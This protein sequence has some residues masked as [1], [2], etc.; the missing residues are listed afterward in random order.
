[1]LTPLSFQAFNRRVTFD[2]DIV[3]TLLQ[4]FIPK[5]RNIKWVLCTG[6]GHE[7]LPQIPRIL[8]QSFVARMSRILRQYY[9]THA[10]LSMRACQNSSAAE[11]M[12]PLLGAQVQILIPQ[13]LRVRSSLTKAASQVARSCDVVKTANVRAEIV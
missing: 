4:K 12:P 2:K 13:A 5:L 8:Y 1:M 9:S 7:I 6:D 10:F 11:L 3:Q